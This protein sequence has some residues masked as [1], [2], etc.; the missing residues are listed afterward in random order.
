MLG[1]Y[2]YSEGI[3]SAWRMGHIYLTDRRTKRG[4]GTEVDLAGLDL[5]AN[6]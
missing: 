6:P 3:Y 5:A 4:P 1:S 2:Y